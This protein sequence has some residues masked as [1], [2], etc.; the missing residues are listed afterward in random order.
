MKTTQTNKKNGVSGSLF[1]WRWAA[2]L[3]VL[4]CLI[5]A[6]RATAGTLTVTSTPIA[7]SG[8]AAYSYSLSTPVNLT[9]EGDLDW[10]KWGR[11]T[12]FDFDHKAGVTPQ[13]GWSY[14]GSLGVWSTSD[15]SSSWVDG[16][17][18]Q[19]CVQYGYGVGMG[20]GLSGNRGGV[21]VNGAGNSFTLTVP[22]STTPVVLHIYAAPYVNPPVPTP[23]T[24]V[25]SLS[26]GSAPTVTIPAG[27][28][29]TRYTVAFAANS[30]AQTLTVNYTATGSGYIGLMAATLSSADPLPLG[31]SQ[32]QLNNGTTLTAG[33]TYS[34]QAIAHGTD[35]NG[36][37]AFTYQWQ[38]S[39]NGG[40]Y[41]NIA[42]ATNWNY[43]ATAALRA[44]IT[45]A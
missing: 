34:V 30:S 21:S 29:S 39:Y 37:S 32:P 18:D 28:V 36:G 22:A 26:D 15:A 16:T 3:A 20:Q 45:T 9:A 40:G 24:L 44:P 14:S 33:S 31:V 5:M 8:L 13:I 11:F 25:F 19:Q 41:A 7:R 10:A 17:V 2:L 12:Q 38:V 42:G 6:G 43:Q 4:A 23:A 27:S 35:I 1:N